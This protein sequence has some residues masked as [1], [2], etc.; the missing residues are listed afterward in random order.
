MS[1]NYF[2]IDIRKCS[3]I[4]GSFICKHFSCR[5]T[6]HTLLKHQTLGDAKCLH[7]KHR[8]LTKASTQ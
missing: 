5:L 7:G 3:R 1:Q 6:I 2:G 8:L 4:E